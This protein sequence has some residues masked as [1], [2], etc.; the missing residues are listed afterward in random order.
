MKRF[1]VTIKDTTAW[2]ITVRAHNRDRAEDLAWELFQHA[3]DRS[4]LF[5]EDSDTTVR[6]EEVVL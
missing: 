4:E 3:A 2:T 6:V 5:T 1:T